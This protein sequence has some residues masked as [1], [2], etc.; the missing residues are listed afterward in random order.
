LLK[1]SVG[2]LV[3]SK[4]L[5]VEVGEVEHSVSHEQNFESLLVEIQFLGEPVEL[6]FPQVLW[7]F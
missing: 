6:N 5:E 4:I 1:L 7:A 3:D 2:K